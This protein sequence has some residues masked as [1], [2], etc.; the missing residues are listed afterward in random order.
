MNAGISGA[1]KGLA[2][3]P[4]GQ[5]NVEQSRSIRDDRTIAIENLQKGPLGGYIGF[6]PIERTQEAHAG[7]Y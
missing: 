3:R 6:R 4:L 2:D 1:V 7:V 5:W